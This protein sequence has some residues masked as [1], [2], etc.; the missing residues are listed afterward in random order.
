M[1]L[2]LAR[3]AAVDKSIVYHDIIVELENRLK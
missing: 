3:Q 2:K 1:L